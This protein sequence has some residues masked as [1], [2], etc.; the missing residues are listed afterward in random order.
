MV[1]GKKA[2]GRQRLSYKDGITEAADIRRIEEV[3][4][5]ARDRKEWKSIVTNVNYD[6]ALR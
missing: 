5:L 6:T 3:T 4:K 2:R 1:E